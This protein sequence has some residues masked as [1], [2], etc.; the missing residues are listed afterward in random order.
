MC[1]WH[2]AG[3]LVIMI[4]TSHT[5][6]F[7]FIMQRNSQYKYSDIYPITRSK[8]EKYNG[9]MNNIYIYISICEIRLPFSAIKLAF[10]WL[11]PR[12]NRRYFADDVFKWN[13]LNEN[14]WISINIP[15]KFVPKGPINIIPAL[16][17]IIAWHR[18]GDKPL[19]EPM[20]TQFIDAYMRQSASMN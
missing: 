9:T 10:N 14:I 16:V 7:H 18:T 3:V 12:Q 6:Y 1:V 19:S 20:M 5:K 4:S 13:F 8:L 17:H 15:L 2:L 11:M